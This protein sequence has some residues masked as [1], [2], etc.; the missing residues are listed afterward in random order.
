[1]G[2]ED[3][4]PPRFAQ[5]QPFADGVAWVR[6]PEAHAWELIDTEGRILIDASA[7][8]L[9]ASR[10]AEGL[11]WVSRDQQGGWFAIDQRNRVIVPGGFEDAKPFH[12]G[13][14][15]IRRDGWG[16]IDRH[17]RVAVQPR[18]RGF[19]TALVTGGPIDG[20][21]EEGLAV[22]DAGDRFGV[23]DRAD[24]LLVTPEH[25]AVRIH[26][27]AFLIADKYGLWGALDRQ[28]ETL[29]ERKYKDLPDV[30]DVIDGRSEEPRPVL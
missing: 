21:T 11:A 15:L 18:W 6:R 13:L 2:Y 27:S 12:N 17:G 16:A 1:V 22:V 9:A 14:A 23:V 28:G 7:G 24:H 3:T 30:L 20:F 8:Y 4:V 10:F 25:A 26:P 29:V 19:A 5:A